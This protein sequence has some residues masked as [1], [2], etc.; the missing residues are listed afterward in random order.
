MLLLGLLIV[1]TTCRVVGWMFGCMRGDGE[2]FGH[3]ARSDATPDPPFSAAITVLSAGQTGQDDQ[4]RRQDSNVQ[5]GAGRPGFGAMPFPFLVQ[6]VHCQ[7]GFPRRWPRKWG[8]PTFS[9]L[10]LG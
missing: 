9:Y 4:K 7:D 6:K 1:A 5:V 2:T 10:L 3:Q 8:I